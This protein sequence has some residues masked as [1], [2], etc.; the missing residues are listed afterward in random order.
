MFRHMRAATK[1][2]TVGAVTLLTLV[3]TGS[4]A[5]AW[6]LTAVPSAT[7]HHPHRHVRTHGHRQLFGVSPRMMTEASRVAR[8]EEGGNWHFAGT[9]FDGGIGWTLAN[10]AHFRKPTWPRYMHDAPPHMQA[11]ALFRFVW[12][13][14]IALPDQD[15]SCTGY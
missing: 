12:H 7:G 15:G 14:G 3:L 6:P 13:F 10:W 5:G 9:T 1:A 8:C 2:Q 11:N 4:V